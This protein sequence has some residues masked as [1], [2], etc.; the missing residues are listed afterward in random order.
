[1]I[2]LLIYQKKKDAQYDLLWRATLILSIKCLLWVWALCL[3]LRNLSFKEKQESSMG[4]IF[5]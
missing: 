1:M 4:P 5:V 3:G 2:C